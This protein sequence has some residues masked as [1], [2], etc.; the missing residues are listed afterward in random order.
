[1]KVNSYKG[2]E[3]R[4]NRQTDRQTNIHSNVFEMGL[5]AEWV[6]FLQEQQEKRIKIGALVPKLCVEMHGKTHKRIV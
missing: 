6:F 5:L 1:M 2:K 4:E 3:K